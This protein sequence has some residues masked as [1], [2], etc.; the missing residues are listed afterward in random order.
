MKNDN[1]AHPLAAIENAAQIVE[2]NDSKPLLAG[3][4]SPVQAACV[5][6]VQAGCETSPIQA[7]CEVS[8]VQAGCEVSPVQAGCEARVQ[9]GCVQAGSPLLAG[10]DD[11]VLRVKSK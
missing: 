6:P 4:G 5:A 9:A 7:G 8:P 1:N 2:R 3:C 10:C 11:G